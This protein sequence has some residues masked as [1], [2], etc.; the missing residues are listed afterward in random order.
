MKKLTQSCVPTYLGMT[1]TTLAIT[2]VGTTT[3]TSTRSHSTCDTVRGCRVNDSDW[4][5]TTKISC[6]TGIAKRGEAEAN[7][8][9]TPEPLLRTRDD[10]DCEVV[11]EDVIIYP[12]DPHWLSE[13]LEN[14]LSELVNPD[15]PADGTWQDRW[16]KVEDVDQGGYFVAFIYIPQVP[17]AT[18]E[19]WR[20]GKDVLGVSSRTHLARHS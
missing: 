14:R 6:S 16:Q 12:E 13:S 7:P 11:L 2:T 19:E 8:T 18:W 3:T 10:D 15:Q 5:T 1:T 17:R 20:T 4:E 9:P